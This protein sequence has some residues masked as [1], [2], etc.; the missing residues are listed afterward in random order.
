MRFAPAAALAFALGWSLHAAS[1]RADV[2]AVVSAKSSV[3]TLTQGEVADIFLGKA[4]RFPNGEPAVPIDQPEGSAVREEFYRKVAGKS[5]SQMKAFWSR[6]IFTGRGEPP[7]HVADDQEVKKR[8]LEDPHA[9]A[10][11]ERALVDS[12]VRVLLAP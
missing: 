5:A 9:I 11:I 2:V 10:Y 1:L 8:L 6:I 4:S 7:A 3:A 12:S